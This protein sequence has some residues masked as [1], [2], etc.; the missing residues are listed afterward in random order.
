M[1]KADLKFR[2]KY[3]SCFFDQVS[4]LFI[5]YRRIISIPMTPKVNQARDMKKWTRECMGIQ[6]AIASL[7]NYDLIIEATSC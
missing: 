4:S 5:L 7:D 1:P 3:T 6:V 2:S